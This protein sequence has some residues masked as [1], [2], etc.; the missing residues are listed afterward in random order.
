MFG[1]AGHGLNIWHWAIL[2]LVVAV[3]FGGPH[4]PGPN[5]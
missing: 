2:S 4:L 3:M 1:S 5:R